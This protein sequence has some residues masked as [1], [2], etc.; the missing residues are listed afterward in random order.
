M[1]R[2]LMRSVGQQTDDKAALHNI[3]DLPLGSA[4]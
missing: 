2:M 1:S 4:Q 3:G